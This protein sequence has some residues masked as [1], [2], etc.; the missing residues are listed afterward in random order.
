MIAGDNN[1]PI[2]YIYID[3]TI[4]NLLHF[5]SKNFGFIIKNIAMASVPWRYRVFEIV[6]LLIIFQ[7]EDRQLREP[8]QLR[9]LQTS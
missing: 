1:S 5:F 6:I 9:D 7:C 8:Y 3:V 4:Q 2:L